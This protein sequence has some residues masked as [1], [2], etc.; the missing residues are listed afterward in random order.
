MNLQGRPKRI[1]TNK[2]R[3]YGTAMREIG[4]DDRQETGR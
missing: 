1:L 2:V 4:L 3:A